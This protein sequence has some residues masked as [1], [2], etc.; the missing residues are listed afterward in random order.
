LQNR[1]APRRRGVLDPP[2]DSYFGEFTGIQ[3]GHVVCPWNRTVEF[4]SV[5]L[6]IPMT[7]SRPTQPSGGHADRTGS[8]PSVVPAEG[9]TKGVDGMEPHKTQDSFF[10]H[11]VSGMRN[12]ILAITRTGDLALLNEEGYRIFGVTPRADDLGQ[13]VAEVL[14][15]HPDVVRQL[16]GAYDL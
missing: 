16:L 13:P 2:P 9:S 12:G 15:A 4:C 14:R 8:G 11:I 3:L 6:S 5:E 1:N 10:R 7:S